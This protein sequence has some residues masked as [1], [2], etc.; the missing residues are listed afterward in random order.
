MLRRTHDTCIHCMT[1]T[2]TNVTSMVDTAHCNPSITA[3]RAPCHKCVRSHHSLAIG[4]VG[5]LRSSSY[6]CVAPCWYHCCGMPAIGIG[7]QL[8]PVAWI[9]QGNKLLLACTV[10]NWC[11]GTWLQ[12][13]LK[14]S[15]S[16]Q[17]KRVDRQNHNVENSSKLMRK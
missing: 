4:D 8:H 13:W 1:G 2:C 12:G 15:R 16:I 6:D 5:E 10:Q 17:Y 3:T 7:W 9:M 14:N 11:A